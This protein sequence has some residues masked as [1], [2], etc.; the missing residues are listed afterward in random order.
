MPKAASTTPTKRTR[1]TQ[2][3]AKQEAESVPTPISA[4]PLKPSE[5]LNRFPP[6]SGKDLTD[7]SEDRRRELAHFA[8][9]LNNDHG[10]ATPAEEFITKLV[11]AHIGIGLTPC[12]VDRYVEEFR[13]DF[14]DMADRVRQFARQY[15]DLMLD[16]EK[17]GA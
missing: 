7:M 16:G 17:E 3:P 5:R 8:E 15:P 4:A 6:L 10:Y 1:P 12:C 13:D 2:S 14:E 11:S 9:I